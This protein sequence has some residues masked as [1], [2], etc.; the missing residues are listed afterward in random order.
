MSCVR[1]MVRLD[2]SEQNAWNTISQ[3]IVGE[4]AGQRIVDPMDAESGAAHLQTD[5]GLA[6]RRG[7][8]GVGETLGIDGSCTYRLIVQAIGGG[9]A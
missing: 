2:P 8:Q 3:E 9:G 7:R 1:R 5:A 4:C 6:N